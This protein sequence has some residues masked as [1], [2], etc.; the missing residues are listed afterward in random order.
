[1]CAR[2]EVAS[3]IL[4]SSQPPGESGGPFEPFPYILIFGGLFFLQFVGAFSLDS[5][6]AVFSHY[7]STQQNEKLA[8]LKIK[9]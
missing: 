1:M 4:S 9:K 8:N 3:R 7:I 6:L 2:K 5:F